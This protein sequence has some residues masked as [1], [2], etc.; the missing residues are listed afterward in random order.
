MNQDRGIGG[1]H[2]VDL[3]QSRFQTAAVAN[4]SEFAF[5]RLVT[6]TRHRNPEHE[7]VLQSF[8]V[9]LD[10]KLSGRVDC[11]AFH[12]AF[13]LQIQPQP[14]DHRKRSPIFNK[15]SLSRR[16][17]LWLLPAVSNIRVSTALCGR[18]SSS[19]CSEWSKKDGADLPF[20]CGLNRF[21]QRFPANGLAEKFYPSSLL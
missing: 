17:L 7:Y 18:G 19:D 4:D 3:L 21:K 8:R 13:A 12:F 16:R 11:F 2:Q 20:H 14:R 5:V 6:I 9:G 15:S 1:R 10:P